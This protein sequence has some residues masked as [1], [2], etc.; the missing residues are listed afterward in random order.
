MKQ[1]KM[2]NFRKLTLFILL[3]IL[4]YVC[5]AIIIKGNRTKSLRENY[6]Y[7]NAI[8]TEYYTISFVFY[9]KYEFIYDGTK[10][11]GS[12][13]RH[14]R[15]IFPAI[16]DSVKIIFDTHNPKNNSVVSE[17]KEM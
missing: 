1:K 9:Y 5:I 6:S 15:S 8:V 13:K 3:F 12:E 11:N 14:S 16:G 4:V 17:N 2:D 7:T 10:F